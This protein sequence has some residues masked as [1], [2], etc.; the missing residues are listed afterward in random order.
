MG[1]VWGA[2]ARDSGGSGGSGGSVHV[3]MAPSGLVLCHHH[4]PERASACAMVVVGVG[5]RDEQEGEHGLA[6]VLEHV[7]FMGTQAFPGINDLSAALDRIGAQHN[8]FTAM[9]QTCYHIRLLARQLPLGIFI[10]SQM[11]LHPLLRQ[12]VLAKELEVIKQEIAR[13]RDDAGSHVEDVAYQALFRSHPTLSHAIAGTEAD[14]GAYTSEHVRAF[15]RKHYRRPRMAL[16]VCAPQP[17]A[18]VRA[19]VR[20]AFEEHEM[21]P[22]P[23]PPVPAPSPP[24]RLEA[25]RARRLSQSRPQLDQTHLCLLFPSAAGYRHR[26]R[27]T[28]QLLSLILGGYSSSRL[29]RLIREANG[30]AYTVSSET[31]EMEDV[32]VLQVYMA[33]ASQHARAALRATA[34][35]LQRVAREGVT[36][37]ELADALGHAEGALAMRLESTHGAAL[38]WADQLVH[39]HLR[40]APHAAAGAPPTRPMSASEEVAV[41]HSIGIEDLHRLARTTLACRNATVIRIGPSVKPST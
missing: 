4:A 12:P 2:P 19:W 38:F 23:P 22:G 33:V 1:G 13:S 29:W 32:T 34:R 24:V 27:Y 9:D 5:S 41:M 30:W 39:T 10:L 31:Y 6:H 18:A 20:R 15:W 14:V 11:V 17:L 8:A 37:Q 16:V 7:V 35:E 25:V 40:R 3:E 28:L 36:E 26:D 21:P